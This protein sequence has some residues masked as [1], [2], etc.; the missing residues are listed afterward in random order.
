MKK[1]MSIIAIITLILGSFPKIGLAAPTE[2]ELGDYLSEIG[3]TKEELI[4]YLDFDGLTIEDFE[5]IDELREYLGPPITEQNLNELLAKYDLTLEE[6]ENLLKENGELDEGEQIQD[7]FFFINDLD[8][9]VS[10]YLDNPLTPISDENLQELL[11]KYGLTKKELEDLLHK[12]G[13]SL[14]NYQ[15]IEDLDM[16]VD[17]YLNYAELINGE[18]A[19]LGI[20]TEEI[21]RLI[22]YLSTLDY[23]NPAFEEK[24]MELAERM[25]AFG[26]FESAEDLTPEQIAELIDIMNDL[27]DLFQL[28]VKYY[29]VKGNERKEVSL[30]ALLAMDS[31]N[32][33]DLLIEIYDLQGNLL[34]DMILTAEM[35]G[36]ELIKETGKD[37]KHVEKVVKTLPEINSK[38]V[39][40]AKL[41]K[42]ASPY[43][44][45]MLL[46]S[47]IVLIGVIL[48][49][50]WKGIYIG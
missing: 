33:Y 2:A 23:E 24:M 3:W 1:W 12:N 40:G 41:P 35:F 20:T 26:D 47:I 31:P 45:N 22:N 38:T 48:F 27:L 46:G 37:I 34:M 18:L 5:T 16:A 28:K 50:K 43:P 7:V 11:D 32:G 10:F 36:S 30:D 9:T 19:K 29:L 49:R 15:Y 21:D 39:K 8:E 17:Y 6:L 13:D 4:E 44:D 14:D 42:T 25:E